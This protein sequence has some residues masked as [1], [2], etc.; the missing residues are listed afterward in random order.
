MTDREKPLSEIDEA[1]SSDDVPMDK[2]RSSLL[3]IF[4]YKVPSAM[5]IKE[6]FQ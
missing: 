2:M 5:M 1:A 3:T 4:T 6:Q